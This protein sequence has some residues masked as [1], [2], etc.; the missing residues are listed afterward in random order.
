MFS[1]IHHLYHFRVQVECFKHSSKCKV[2]ILTTFPEGVRRKASKKIQKM[3]TLIF[4]AI[5]KFCT[6]N[7]LF[8]F[9]LMILYDCEVRVYLHIDTRFFNKFEED[10][11]LQVD[12]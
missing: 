6:F 12:K 7:H 4:I 5:L 2:V 8:N 11:I 10:S 3:T 1:N 9:L